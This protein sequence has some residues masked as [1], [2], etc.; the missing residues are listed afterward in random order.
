MT[1]NTIFTYEGKEYWKRL[2]SNEELADLSDNWE[3]PTVDTAK[4]FQTVLRC[5]EVCEEF[6]NICKAEGIVCQV[7]NKDWFTKKSIPAR[8]YVEG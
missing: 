3:N 4:Y 1:E 6:Y 7:V 2:I 5:Y 8:F